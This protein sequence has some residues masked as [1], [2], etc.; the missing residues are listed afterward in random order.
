MDPNPINPD[1][2]APVNPR[3]DLTPEQYRASEAMGSEMAGILIPGAIDFNEA[4]AAGLPRD[5]R[6]YM[7]TM[8]QALHARPDQQ[9]GL[10]VPAR[11]DLP[12]EPGGDAPAVR[13]QPQFFAGLSPL[14]GV[15]P[16]GGPGAPAAASRA[17]S[18]STSSSTGRA[19]PARRLSTLN[20][21]TVAGVGKVFN[22]GGRLLA[23][24]ANQVV[25][26][27]IGKNSSQPTV[28]SFLPLTLVQPFLRGGGR[29]VTLEPLTQAERNLVYQIR[30][31]AKFRQEFIVATLVGG[32][33]P[34][35]R[36]GRRRR[37]GSRGGGNTDPIIG[38]INVLEDIQVVEN[39]RKNI[40]AFEQLVKVYTR[41]DR[42]RVVGPVAAAARPGR[43]EPPERPAA[44]RR[45]P[46]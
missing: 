32:L 23:G 22:T 1:L 10:S 37:W 27:F 3:P 38:F 9:P 44:A 39:D 35:P 2:S 14:T 28:Q 13:V 7:I 19:R 31:F 33:D 17:R 30:A 21:G 42:G 24:F 5:S 34:E 43:L 40:A 16:G 18:R 12:R 29:A 6:P 8:E 36:L 26:N 45:R 4:E 15:A 41:A 25:F 20:L 46:D 11:A